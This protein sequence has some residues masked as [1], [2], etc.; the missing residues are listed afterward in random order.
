MT[1]Y[2]WTGAS[3]TDWNNPNNW[4]VT[5]DTILTTTTGVPGLADNVLIMS[6]NL[7]NKAGYTYNG[8]S[9]S[10]NNVVKNMTPILSGS[11]PVTV[12]NV[13]LGGNCGPAT[14]STGSTPFI[15]TG[16]LQDPQ[17]AGFKNAQGGSYS[18]QG[19]NIH[20]F[21]LVL[22]TE[23]KVSYGTESTPAKVTVEWLTGA[24]QNYNG[25]NS[26]MTV[27]KGYDVNSSGS[28]S[29]Q[30]GKDGNNNWK[31]TYADGAEKRY[32]NA[33]FLTGSR[34]R[35]L[36]G[37]MAV[38]DISPTDSVIAC[39]N[40]QDVARA[41]VWA[42]KAHVVVN[43][44]LPEEAAG[45]PVRIVKDA[46]AQG[47]PSQD[48]LVTSEHCLFLDG[49][50][51][52]VRMLV[53]GRSIFYDTSITSYDHYHLETEEHSVITANGILTES[54]LDTGSRR[55]FRPGGSVASLG[56]RTLTW[57]HDA[58]APLDVSRAFVEPHFLRLR[59]RAAAMGIPSLTIACSTT[60]DAD[61]R[62]LTETGHII[63]PAR[64]QGDLVMFMVPSSVRNIHILSR[65][66]RPSKAI[67]PFIDDHR[68]LGV[69]IGQ[70]TLFDS[71]K[72]AK[73]DQHLKTES[74]SGWEAREHI[75]ARWTNG[76][77]KLSLNARTPDGIGMLVLQILASGPYAIEQ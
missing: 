71:V 5:K 49:T 77:A 61:L 26:A 56:I 4:N 62:L 68:E 63:R 40:G 13:T 14:L 34:I 16:K 19:T 59:Q 25:N 54:Y 45:Y 75:P 46:L 1:S 53:N 29:F 38:E 47:L 30:S 44:A 76:Y 37:E 52:P 51:V 48:L 23:G 50:F 64:I 74:L 32:S 73:I 39:V 58:A 6:G 31:I 72:K 43:A 60:D 7:L 17:S 36:R 21:H 70:I 3:N 57:E 42:G 27:T 9:N 24:G 11:T 33:C 65:A 67:G 41:V 28:P 8:D 15:V 12:A 20:L 69:L 66:S 35:T 55:A 10:I 18:L 22:G 2:L